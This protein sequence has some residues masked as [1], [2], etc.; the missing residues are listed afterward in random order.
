MAKQAVGEVDPEAAWSALTGPG[1]TLLIDVRSQAEWA[2]VGLPDLTDAGAE[3]V[4]IEWQVFPTMT[5]N[6]GFA[7][8]ALSAISDHGA[9][10]V[11]FLC[12]SGARSMHAAWA[13]AEALE[14]SAVGAGGVEG[15]GER[16]AESGGGAVR[17]FNVAEGFEGDLDVSGKRGAL[18]GWKARGL[19]WRQS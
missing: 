8:A 2:F 11:Y 3:P 5:P 9:E 4:L 17:C 19:P 10:E 12:R 15:G 6:H 16:G 1:K 14:T 7:G 18:N 13:T